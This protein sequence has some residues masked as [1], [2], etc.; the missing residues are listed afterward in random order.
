MKCVLSIRK[1][2]TERVDAFFYEIL[3]PAG[4]FSSRLAL[5][6]FDAGHKVDIESD[7]RTFLSFTEELFIRQEQGEPYLAESAMAELDALLGEI[8]SPG[9]IRQAVERGEETHKVLEEDVRKE[10]LL[11][12]GYRVT[13]Y[14]RVEQS[15]GETLAPFIREDGTKVAEGEEDTP[16]KVPY[17]IPCAPVIDPVKGT[18]VGSLQNGDQILLRLPEDENAPV[19]EKLRRAS[20]DFDGVAAGEVIS[21]HQDRGGGFTVLV[22]L[23][24]EFKGVV[25]ME[26]NSRIRT[27]SLA[28][29]PTAL[30][31]ALHPANGASADESSP[32]ESKPPGENSFYT[33][34]FLLTAS[35]L[36]LV[37]VLLY[38]RFIF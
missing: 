14:L 20:P 31:E 1:S 23:S 32:T 13:V 24:D 30:S 22:H 27:G 3:S 25:S 36:V 7:V 26:G 17:L 29:R 28:A 21:V 9:E 6:P 37:L 19:L 12:L 2:R 5:I 35:M 18:A 38:F 4:V 33:P 11:R 15:D 8:L 10:I 34:Y 16:G